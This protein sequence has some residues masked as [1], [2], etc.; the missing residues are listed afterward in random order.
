[1][2]EFAKN[3][4]KSTSL[5]NAEVQGM[6]G[7]GYKVLSGKAI[8]ARQQ[9]G[10]VGNEDLFDNQLLGDKIVGMQLIPMIQQIFTASRVERIVSDQMD[11]ATSRI[12]QMLSNKRTELPTIVDRALKGEY[13]YI[14]DRAGGGLSAREQ[15]GDRL[16]R[17]TEK[18]AQYGQVPISLIMAT[19]KYMD[20]PGPDL[21]AIKVEV[22]QQAKMAQAQQMSG[23]I[24]GERPNA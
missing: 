12:A 4:I 24:P 19:L 7:E 14:I 16:E 15:M 11:M 5:V 3:Q 13:D 23:M 22:M 18:W 8:Q 6:P 20:L 21:E 2:I 9:G 1:M 17:I 10:L